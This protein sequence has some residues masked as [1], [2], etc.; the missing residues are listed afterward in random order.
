MEAIGLDLL[1]SEN[2]MKWDNATVPMRD[3]SWFDKTFSNPFHNE[4]FSI[5][6]PVMTGVEHIQSILDIK[7]APA[8]L[9]KIVQECTHLTEKDRYALREVLARYEDLFDGSLGTWKAEPVELELRPDAKPYPVPHSL[10]KRMTEI[11]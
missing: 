7:Y 2:L 5:D 9:D 8:D 10:K 4:L 6:D 3:S 11:N 1:F